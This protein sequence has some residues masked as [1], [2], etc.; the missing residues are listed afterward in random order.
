MR[1]VR[2]RRRGF[3]DLRRITIGDYIILVS[4]AMTLASLFMTWF[5]TTLPGAHDQW[6]FTYSEVASVVVIVFF[7]ATLFLVIYPAVSRDAGLPPLPFAT[8]LVFLTMGSILLLLFT[9]ELG[10]YD[11]IQCQ[12]GGVGRGFGIWVAFV[13][14]WA[15]LVGAIV[16]WGS[17][18]TRTA[19]R[20]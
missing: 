8:P 20:A 6:A 2:P 3:I 11:C 13:S 19:D 14:A 16:K 10:K 4:S 18:P 17:R 7:L 15:Y 1:R 9:F 5:V 12:V